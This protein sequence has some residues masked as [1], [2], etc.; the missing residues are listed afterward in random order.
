MTNTLPYSIDSHTDSMYVTY[1]LY[2]D[3]STE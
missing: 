1:R 3:H 2:D